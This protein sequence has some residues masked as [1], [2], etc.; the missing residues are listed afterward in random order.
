AHPWAGPAPCPPD[1]PRPAGGER[2]DRRRTPSGEH[3][4]PV[5]SGA[6][7]SEPCP[8]AGQ[9]GP[10]QTVGAEALTPRPVAR[11]DAPVTTT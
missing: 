2:S 8:R 1:R 5:G 6:G 4:H 10:S 3:P 9:A 7:A 11:D